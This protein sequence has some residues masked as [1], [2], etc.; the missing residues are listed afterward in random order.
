MAHFPSGASRFGPL[1]LSEDV[2]SL[3]RAMFGN[4]HLALF[5][6]DFAIKA[7]MLVNLFVVGGLITSTGGTKRS[8]FTSALFALPIFSIFLWEAYPIVLVHIVLTGLTALACNV[9][10]PA[11]EQEEDGGL[12]FFFVAGAI[13]VL[14]TYLSYVTRKL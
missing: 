9:S 1:I 8:P 6:L 13:M 4:R 10:P 5:S 12:S 11:W 14:T 2:T 3:G 7:T